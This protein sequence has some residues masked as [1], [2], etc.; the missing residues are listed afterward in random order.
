MKARPAMLVAFIL[1]TALVL[2]GA[3]L[4]GCKASVSDEASCEA[5]GGMEQRGA[6]PPAYIE[7]PPGKEKVGEPWKRENYHAICCVPEE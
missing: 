7:C 4:P 3:V 1:M 2:S 5:V 6:V